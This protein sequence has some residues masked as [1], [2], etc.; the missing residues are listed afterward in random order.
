MGTQR[1]QEITQE[2]LQDELNY[3]HDLTVRYLENWRQEANK[4]GYMLDNFIFDYKNFSKQL[5]SMPEFMNYHEYMS[6]QNAIMNIARR[7]GIHLGM[8]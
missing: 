1:F 2:V 4:K 7:L 8:K 5:Y 6:M 3:A